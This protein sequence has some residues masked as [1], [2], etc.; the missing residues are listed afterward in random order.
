MNRVLVGTVLKAQGIKGEV[1]VH[2]D[3]SA[4]EQ[5]LHWKNLYLEDSFVAVESARLVGGYVYLLFSTIRDRNQAELLRG[6]KLYV[7]RD[8]FH[9]KENDYFIEDLIGCVVS[10]DE[11]QTLGTLEE[12]YQNG[13]VDTLVVKGDRIVMFP[14]LKR[15]LLAVLP[16]ERKIVLRAKELAEVIYYED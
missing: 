3:V 13:Q 9:L 16:E 6:K 1:K 10:T 12:V 7:D 2:P 5:F 8:R 11:E 15:I 14:F 4:P